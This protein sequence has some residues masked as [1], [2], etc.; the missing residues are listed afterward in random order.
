MYIGKNKRK[1]CPPPHTHFLKTSSSI[2]SWCPSLR[3]Q[4]HIGI[5]RGNTFICIQNLYQFI[6]SC[7]TAHSN[8]I[9][10]QNAMP[11]AVLLINSYPASN[12]SFTLAML[13]K[14]HIRSHPQR[15]FKSAGWYSKLP[16]GMA[17]NGFVALRTIHMAHFS[18]P[19]WSK[20][21]TWSNWNGSFWKF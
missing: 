4:R 1:H 7:Q 10:D 9:R 12:L 16:W 14:M 5:C 20:M 6:C 18:V 13:A 3:W 2:Q 15:G 11:S 8:S 17:S 19:K 21:A